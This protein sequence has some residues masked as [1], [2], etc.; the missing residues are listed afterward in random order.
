MNLDPPDWL[1]VLGGALQIGGVLVLVVDVVRTF[2]RLEE[3]GRR[4]QTIEGTTLEAPVTLPRAT[5]TGG[6][7]PTVDERLGRLERGLDEIRVELPERIARAEAK[8]RESSSE[9]AGRAVRHTDR[10]FD[11]LEGALLGDTTRDKWRR[12]GSIAAIVL[13]LILATIG[14][15]MP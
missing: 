2:R 11:A 15:V 6:A 5:V 8:A 1:V 14:S 7:P 3:Y 12:L 10:R 4:P 13:G 9:A